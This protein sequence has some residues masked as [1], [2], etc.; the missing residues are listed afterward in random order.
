MHRLGRALEDD[1]LDAVAR[2]PGAP[3]VPE[4]H[5]AMVTR[6]LR[7]LGATCLVQS[8]ILQRWDTDHGHPRP[9]VIGVARQGGEF[10]AHAWLEG[11]WAPGEF[12]ELH[13]RPAPGG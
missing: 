9:L 8:A 4:A 12:V 11:D 2:I 13:R 3:A 7:L 5:R 10:A 6:T 1:G